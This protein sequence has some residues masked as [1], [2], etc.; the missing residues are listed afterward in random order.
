M[1]INCIDLVRSFF[2]RINCEMQIGLF[3][4][5]S[6]AEHVLAFFVFLGQIE[7]QCSHKMSSYKK[8]AIVCIHISKCWSWYAS[9]ELE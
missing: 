2:L 3:N 1:F 6:E 8:D 7:P 5:S 4:F 9:E